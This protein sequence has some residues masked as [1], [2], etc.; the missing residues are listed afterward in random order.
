MKDMRSFIFCFSFS[1]IFGFFTCN[2]A[3]GKIA[4]WE[5]LPRGANAFSELSLK[6]LKDAKASGINV[7][8][9]GAVGQHQD[10]KYLV[11]NDSW[12]FSK[13]NTDRLEQSIKQARE[14]GI[15]VI[16]TLSE[17]PGRK[18]EFK[19]HDYRIFADYQYHKKFTDGW[20]TIAKILASYDNVIGYDLLNEPLF[21]E[22]ADDKSID[23][24]N[25]Q[26]SIKGTPKDINHLYKQTITAIREVDKNTPI[27]IQP[28]S[29]GSR[30]ALDILERQSDEKVIYSFHYYDP[31]P[32]FAKRKNKGKIKYPGLVPQWINEKGK[33]PGRNW[34]HATHLKELLKA[35]SWA[36]KHSIPAHRIFV[37]E[38]GVWREAPGAEVYLKDVLGIF[39]DM[40]WS[41]TYYSY[42]ESGWDNVDLELADDTGKNRK[43]FELIKPN[44]R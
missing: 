34:N 24:Q 13:K 19:K 12:D 44:F 10:L 23:Y 43:L 39:K 28:T 27:I 42:R 38:F 22:E 3:F 35:K 9:I 30:D 36:D 25:L 5:K 29:W 1:C 26:K 2:K 16:L 40:G 18:W 31:F 14:A 33:G 17:V 7:I 8:R 4:T 21:P 41:W 11:K 32:Y 6:D 20:K 37:G 15:Q